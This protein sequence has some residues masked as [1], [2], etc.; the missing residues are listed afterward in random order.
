[1]YEITQAVIVPNPK[2]D[3]Y[4][5]SECW[6]LGPDHRRAARLVVQASDEF[7][8]KFAARDTDW[9]SAV[10]GVRESFMESLSS[11]PLAIVQ[12]EYRV[13]YDAPEG[14]NRVRA[15]LSR[16]KP[17]ARPLFLW[18]KIGDPVRLGD[19]QPLGA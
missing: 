14:A 16:R 2:H 12:G 11:S 6:I 5:R 13:L 4:V 8:A 3:G 17:D 15:A 9:P 7:A 10:D 19:F 18:A 1:M